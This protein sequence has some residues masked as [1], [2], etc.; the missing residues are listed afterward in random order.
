MRGEGFG[1][2]WVG[3]GGDGEVVGCGMCEEGMEGGCCGGGGGV[4]DVG[5]GV[6]DPFD[7]R[8]SGRW[9]VCRCEGADVGG[10]EVV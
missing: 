5:R 6:V 10:C 8:G 9:V 3:E 7:F 2:L 1:G 4:E